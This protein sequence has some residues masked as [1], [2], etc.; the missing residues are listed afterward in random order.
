[1][2]IG[3]VY[4][5]IP[6]SACWGLVSY[7][8]KY[9]YVLIWGILVVIANDIGGYVFGKVIGGYKLAPRIS[10]KKTWA[11]LMGGLIFIA[12]FNWSY[13]HLISFEMPRY[14]FLFTSLIL[15]GISTLGDL[16]E[17]GI[18]RYHGRKDSGDLIPGHGG[19]LDRLDGFFVTIPFLA[20][21]VYLQ[22]Q[23]FNEA[24]PDASFLTVLLENEGV[25]D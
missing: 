6:V 13:F 19:L 5:G 22:P 7:F 17:S 12:F 16:F 25:L 9:I 24:I 20:L 8:D 1:M 10:P 23:F 21:L 3:V 15:G 14:L 11:G 4:I 2:G 18:K